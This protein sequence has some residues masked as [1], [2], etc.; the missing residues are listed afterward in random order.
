MEYLITH[1]IGENPTAKKE[2]SFLQGH[3][4]NGIIQAQGEE[5]GDIWS[6]IV[7]DNIVSV[8]DAISPGSTISCPKCHHNFS[9]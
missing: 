2:L 5:M 8:K 4:L 1:F 9:V 3:K 6:L 7:E